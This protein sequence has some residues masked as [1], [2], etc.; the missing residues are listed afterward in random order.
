MEAALGP[1]PTGTELI[2]SCSGCLLGLGWGSAFPDGPS[3][4]GAGGALCEL[5]GPGSLGG[6]WRPHSRYV[7]ADMPRPRPGPRGSEG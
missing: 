1:R 4:Q 3:D 5:A 2:K 7:T 6:G